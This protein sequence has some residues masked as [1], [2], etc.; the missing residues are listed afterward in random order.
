LRTRHGEIHGAILI[1][2]VSEGAEA[3]G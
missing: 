3:A 2:A 1:M